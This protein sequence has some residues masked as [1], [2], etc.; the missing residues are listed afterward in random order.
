MN[1]STE[2]IVLAHLTERNSRIT[3]ETWTSESFFAN[4]IMLR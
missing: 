2:F 4:T 3:S 1:D